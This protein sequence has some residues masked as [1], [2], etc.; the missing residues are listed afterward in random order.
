MTSLLPCRAC[1]DA[2]KAVEAINIDGDP[3]A[4]YLI[5]AARK[6]RES[7]KHRTALASEQ[8]EVDPTLRLR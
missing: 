7:C 8:T 6:I 3:Y 5:R 2:A 1:E 4:P